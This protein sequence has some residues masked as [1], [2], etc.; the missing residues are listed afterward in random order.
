MK[1]L[2]EGGTPAAPGA[3]TGVL[4]FAKVKGTE[5]TFPNADEPP[6]PFRSTQCPPPTS[7]PSSGRAIAARPSRSWMMTYCRPSCDQLDMP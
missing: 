6:I 1:T 4:Y 5:G 2:A 3:A 7:S